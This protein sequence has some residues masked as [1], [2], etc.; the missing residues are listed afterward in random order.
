MKLKHL[1]LLVFLSLMIASSSLSAQ[2]WGGI[3]NGAK[4]TANAVKNKKKNNNNQN[5]TSTDDQNQTNVDDDQTTIDDNQS[6]TPDD[7]Q[8]NSVPNLDLTRPVLTAYST[9]FDKLLLDVTTGELSIKEADFINLPDANYG[10]GGNDHSFKGLL[11]L[12]DEV[13]AEFPFAGN[14]SSSFKASK[15]TQRNPQWEQAKFTVTQA[16]N[17]SMEFQIDGQKVDEVFFDII[18]VVNA[19]NL[20]G[21]FINQ[22]INDLGLVG[23]NNF[24]YSQPGMNTYFIFKLYDAELNP[25]PNVYSSDKWPMSV[26]LMKVNPNGKDEYIGGKL[27][28][29]FSHQKWNLRW[30]LCD[31][32][33]FEKS[34]GEKLSYG[35]IVQNDG[36]YYV[37]LFLNGEHYQY[38]FKVVNGELVSD[39]SDRSFGGQILIERII[40][41]KNK[42]SDFRPTVA[43]AGKADNVS[44]TVKSVDG[45]TS[46]GCGAGKPVN[47]K[48]GQQIFAF[49]KP[50]A[51]VDK[52]MYEPVEYI[53]TLKKG[54]D[55]IAQ[56]IIEGFYTG[57]GNF[58][59]LTS[60]GNFVI[61]QN[62]NTHVFMKAMAALPAG[63]NNLTLVYEIA[64]GNETELVGV[65]KITFNSKAG[66]P[67]Y[68]KWADKTE[69]R[70]AMS[71][72]ELS[73]AW[74]LNS[75]S[76]DWAYYQNNCGTVVWLRQDEYKEYFLY[77]GDMELF[78][79]AGGTLEQWNFGT[80]E[81]NTINDFD[82]YKTIYKLTQNDI[83]ILNMKQ[84]PNTDKLNDIMDI[85]FNS[86]DEFLSKVVSLIGQDAVDNQEE[87]IIEQ[88]SYDFVKT[89]N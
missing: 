25:D 71:Q 87:L 45:A 52:F 84:L 28:S 67:I 24:T 86:Q 74:F 63:A 78:D 29:D 55:I 76:N 32:I 68:T 17:Y 73:D 12:D 21:F 82:P 53:T 44:L 60:D 70:A 10:F 65:Q 22:P 14:Y 75:G 5:G 8:T 35:D 48:D 2:N 62:Y 61:K 3:V 39:L 15:L 49:P 40:V 47:I 20:C 33:F 69:K 36:D 79:R 4:N 83:A 23:T 30:K 42:Y 1:Y 80:L 11:K 46:V 57:D 89:C 88:A 54:D 56:H 59:K 81:W 41:P 77:P 43:T 34:D 85:E 58:S 18:Q 9:F 19:D 31:N 66:N 26:R 51:S 7:N 37:D 64:S 27:N 50:S 6:T 16:G 72:A 13:L 38:L